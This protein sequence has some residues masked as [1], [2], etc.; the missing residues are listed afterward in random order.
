MNSEIKIIF[1]DL[2]ETIYNHS[3]NKHV[4]DIKS[5]KALTKA[6]KKGCKVF[7]STAR[8]YD[9]LLQ[10]GIF[11]VFKP[12]GVVVANGTVVYIGDQ[13]I[14][15]DYFPLDIARKVMEVCDK[16]NIC[17]EVSAKKDR[18][19]T[20]PVDD[21]VKGYFEVYH[22]TVPEIHK[23][24][25]EE[26]CAILIFSPEELDET[27]KKEFPPNLNLLRFTKYGIDLRYHYIDKSQGVEDVIKYYGFDK[28]QSMSFGDSIGDVGMF[29]CT[30]ISVS[31]GN[32]RAIAKENATFISKPIEK[33][34]VRYALKKYKII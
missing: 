23:Y 33:H 10:T 31:M 20:L 27:F 8:P 9:S 4:F 25:D 24:N 14:R 21:Y 6:Q 15:N 32:G 29:K 3:N 19:F 13:L 16:Y 30:G 22:E 1:T 12:D 34:G 26:A 7:I 18:Y 17:V 2:D 11:D 5:I 28:S